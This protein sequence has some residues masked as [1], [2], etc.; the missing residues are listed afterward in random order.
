MA[1]TDTQSLIATDLDFEARE[2]RIGALEVPFSRN[3]SAWGTLRIPIGC[4]HGS[5][6]P[7]ML[8]TGGSHGDEYEGPVALLNAMRA[9][10]ARPVAG[11]VIVIPALNLPALL[12]GQRLSP[13]DGRNMN[14]VFPGDPRGTITEQIADYVASR[15]LPLAD[16]VVDMHSGGQSLRFLPAAIMHHLDDRVLHERTLAAM[17]AFGAPVGLVLRELDSRGMLD[18]VVESAGKIFV[19]T[20]L[21]GAATLSPETV[22][23]ARRGVHNLLV[24][25]G[26]IDDAPETAPAPTRVMEVPDGSFYVA[27]EEDGLF[28][29]FIDLGDTVEAGEPV[30][31]LHFIQTP[32]RAPRLHVA[33]RSGML[34]CRRAQGWT[35]QGDCLAVLA[36]DAGAA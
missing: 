18:T 4:F 2:S 19:S 27:A 5:D 30:G 10:K 32:D 9:L 11:R 6:G 17:T 7:T 28:E 13:I 29:P 14:R 25:F 35:E 33:R 8:L 16:I 3:E 34:I 31:R 24:H 1:V 20:E 26:L 12:A 22:A 21:G 23:I 15:L 36:V